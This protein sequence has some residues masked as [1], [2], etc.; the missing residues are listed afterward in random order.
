MLCFVA[1]S[2]MKHIEICFTM[3]RWVGRN[4]WM[5]MPVS[6][7]EFLFDASFEL[8]FMQVQKIRKLRLDSMQVWSS[9]FEFLNS[10]LASKRNLELVTCITIHLLHYYSANSALH[11]EANFMR[12]TKVS[13][14]F[15]KLLEWG[16]SLEGYNNKSLKICITRRQS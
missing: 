1:N 10:E 4:K 9:T 14:L 2:L 13:T 15:C 3:K 8:P 6:S 11:G 5:V 7:F 16:A 12:F